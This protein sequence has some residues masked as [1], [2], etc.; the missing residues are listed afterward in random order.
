MAD[1]DNQSEKRK[2]KKEKRDF[3]AEILEFLSSHPTGCTIKDVAKGITASRTTIYKY[4]Y[5]LQL[6]K[7]ITK[8]KIGAYYLHFNINRKFISNKL[9]ID[10][11]KGLLSGLKRKFPN[12]QDIFKKVGREMVKY[13]QLSLKYLPIFEEDLDSFKN[14]TVKNFLK[15]FSE[16]Y[17]YFDIYQQPLEVSDIEINYEESTATY[18]FLNS[19]LL[20][21]TNEFIYHFYIM[22]GLI[23]ATSSKFFNKNV[24]CCVENIQIK[25]NY[26]ESYVDISIKIK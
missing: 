14:L 26:K 25:E 7:K 2:S 17:P 13:Y 18:R 10:Y 24:T 5:Q 19:G 20:E 21:S 3:E 9:V 6:K 16:F 22:C 15:I 11:Y 12:H 4:I 23:E 1:S 8:K